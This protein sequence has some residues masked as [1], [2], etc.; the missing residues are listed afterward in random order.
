MKDLKEERPKIRIITDIALDLFTNY[1]Q[2][3]LI[4][5]NGHVIND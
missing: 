2:D 3:G 1:E 4:D 5:S